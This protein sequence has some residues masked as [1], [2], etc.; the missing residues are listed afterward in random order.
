MRIPFVIVLMICM[1]IYGCM[2]KTE[3]AP[4]DYRTLLTAD[5][6]APLLQQEADQYMSLY[7][8]VKIQVRSALSREAIVL[9]LNDSVQSIVTDRQFNEEEQQVIQ[10][11]GLKVSESRIA[12]EGMAIIVHKQNPI[13][14]IRTES[15]RSIVHGTVKDWRQ[16]AEA[17]WSGDIDF[18][19]TGKNSGMY[20]LL[21]KKFFPVS[22]AL[23]PT[24]FLTNQRDVLRYVAAHPQS[25][26]F[27]AASFVNDSAGQFKVLPVRVRSSAGEE[28]DYV[29]QQQEIFS[30][31]Y[32]FHFSLYLY[33]TETKT[34]VGNGFSALVLSNVGQKII[35]RAGLVPVSIPYR[36]IQLHAE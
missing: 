12:E 25:I 1:G 30:A 3:P 4:P 36:T 6:Y 35:Q 29:P 11:A 5:P 19:L 28:K 20:E 13:S 24:M 8:D 23:E 27:V 22:K 17:H 2:K 31:L 14:S 16:I 34:S 15:L 10:E 26:G 9:L 18:V 21:Q 32:P 33:T 7:S